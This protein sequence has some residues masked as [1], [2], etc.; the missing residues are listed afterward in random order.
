MTFK[1]DLLRIAII[2]GLVTAIVIT[3]SAHSA[4]PVFVDAELIEF[5]SASYTYPPSPFKIKQAKKLGIP[6]EV[7]TDPSVSLTGYLERPA[8]EES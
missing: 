5:E 3:K 4:E 8:G 1:N 2:T 6:V 7:K